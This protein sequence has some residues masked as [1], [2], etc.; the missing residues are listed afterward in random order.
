M[1]AKEID[2]LLVLAKDAFATQSTLIEINPPV[3]VCGDVH[4]QFSDLLRIFHHHG[5]PPATNY[6]FLGDYIDRGPQSIETILLLLCYK[7]KY[8][9]QFFLLKG[10]HEMETINRVYGFWHEVVRRFQTDVLYAKF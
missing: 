2:E 10:N 3:V 6:L 8:P 1:S 5:F 9:N 7:I 4:G